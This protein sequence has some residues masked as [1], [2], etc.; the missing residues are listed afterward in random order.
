MRLNGVDSPHQDF[1]VDLPNPDFGYETIIRMPL[2]FSKLSNGEISV[3]DEGGEYDIYSVKCS[4]V[5]PYDKMRLFNYLY[6]NAQRGRMLSLTDCLTAG[7]CPFTP[8]VVSANESITDSYTVTL[9]N[10]NLKGPVDNLAKGFRVD[11]EMLLSYESLTFAPEQEAAPEGSI[12]LINSVGDIDTTGIRFPINGFSPTVGYN[13][14]GR[15][16]LGG[17]TETVNY[18]YFKAS[19]PRASSMTITANQ[20]AASNIIR[21]REY[22]DKRYRV[23]F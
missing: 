20:R 18:D 2:H 10:V 8:A 3:F 7:F 23:C 9:N 1:D 16:M 11:F 6:D 5:M 19:E 14:Y 13:A 15:Q 22:T 12:R 17:V 21:R 4:C